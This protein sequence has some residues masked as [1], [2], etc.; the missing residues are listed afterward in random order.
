VRPV[1]RSQTGTALLLAVGVLF[2]V[3]W[4]CLDL[5][6]SG[7]RSMWTGELAKRELI[8]EIEVR[9]ALARLMDAMAAASRTRKHNTL[10]DPWIVARKFPTVNAMG[11]MK[12][13][14]EV[15]DLSGLFP[16]NLILD[17]QGRENKLYLELLQRLLAL[18]EFGFPVERQRIMV[19]SLLDWLDPDSSPRENG[20][21]AAYYQHRRRPHA[22]AN[23]PMG[24]ISEL[25][26]VRGFSPDTPAIAKGITALTSVLTVDAPQ[27]K[28]NINTAPVEILLCLAPDM[29]EETAR[30]M[31][32][33]RE[34]MQ[35][36]AALAGPDWYT[37]VSSW[38]PGKVLSPNVLTIRSSAFSARFTVSTETGTTT[39]SAV[40]HTTPDGTVVLA[41][42]LLH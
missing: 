6:A 25:A 11:T 36:I 41:S 5:F 37:Q 23:R 22:A 18:P 30:E 31:A 24:H 32:L 9:S 12:T 35:N 10:H 39:L 26:L 3:S 17:T 34:N 2:M 8:R 29:T 20:A 1:L 40:I 42:Q 16:I 19:D 15:R 4:V 21:E 33:F 14:V 13:S 38:P 7:S 28:I 27:G